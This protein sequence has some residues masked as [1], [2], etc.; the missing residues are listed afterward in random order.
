MKTTFENKTS[1]VFHSQSYIMKLP[2]Y[3]YTLHLFISNT[4]TKL[5][6]LKASVLCIWACIF[7]MGFCDRKS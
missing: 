1:Q 3:S 4:Q 2:A 7:S 6:N 5:D